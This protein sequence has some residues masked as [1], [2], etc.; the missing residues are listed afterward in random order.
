[1]LL[2]LLLLRTV[3]SWL[4]VQSVDP[5]GLLRALVL[6]IRDASGWKP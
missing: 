6:D 3:T 2:D 5:N 1:V 4:P